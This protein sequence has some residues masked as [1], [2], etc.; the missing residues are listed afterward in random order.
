MT[1]TTIRVDQ[2]VRDRLARLAQSHGR[3]LGAELDAILDDLAW[4]AIEDGYCRLGRDQTAMDGYAAEADEVAA[5]DL[6]ELA[7]GAADEYPEY[8]GVGS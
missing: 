8:N 5:A 7:A 1:M 3:S 6:E 4:Q 2:A